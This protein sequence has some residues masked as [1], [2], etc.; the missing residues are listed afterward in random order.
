MIN[1]FL[2]LLGYQYFTTD[3]KRFKIHKIG[4]IHAKGTSKKKIYLTRKQA[5]ALKVK[6]TKDSCSHCIVSLAKTN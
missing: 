1:L 5:F 4:C 3:D 6:G 2:M